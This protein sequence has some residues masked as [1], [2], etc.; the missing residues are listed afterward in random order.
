MIIDPVHCTE[1]GSA[2]AAGLGTVPAPA[3]AGGPAGSDPVKSISSRPTDL[4]PHHV[5]ECGCD[6]EITLHVAGDGFASWRVSHNSFDRRELNEQ[7]C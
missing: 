5:E 2:A 6:P 1:I 3:V 4:Q 7:T